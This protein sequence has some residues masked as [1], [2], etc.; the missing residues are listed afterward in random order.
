MAIDRAAERLNVARTLLEEGS[1]VT[2]RKATWTANTSGVGRI[3]STPTSY[4]VPALVTSFSASQING[5]TIRN[6]DCKILLAALTSALVAYPA[7]AED[8]QIVVDGR[9]LEII[10]PGPILGDGT[11]IVYK[12]HAGVDK[13]SRGAVVGMGHQQ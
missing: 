8:D 3:R 12:V 10:N 13:A 2:L 5:S 7:L 4:T 6:G 9:V 1:T 11:T